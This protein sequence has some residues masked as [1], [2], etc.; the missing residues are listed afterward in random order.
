MNFFFTEFECL[1]PFFAYTLRSLAIIFTRAVTHWTTAAWR[2]LIRLQKISTYLYLLEEAVGKKIHEKHRLEQTNKAEKEE[3]S[4]TIE[5]NAPAVWNNWKVV[6]AR[7][8]RHDFGFSFLPHEAH[9]IDHEREETSFFCCRWALEPRES[10]ARLNYSPPCSVLHGNFSFSHC[11]L[12]ANNW[13]WATFSFNYHRSQAH[14]QVH[15]D[16]FRMQKVSSSPLQFI[17][18]A[19]KLTMRIKEEKKNTFKAFDWKWKRND[20]KQKEFCASSSW[21]VAN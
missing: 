14:S 19:H 16:E 10:L 9:V 1:S 20:A 8:S 3:R 17:V 21:H 12:S 7:K 18:V 15:N 2:L 11:S 13:R 6:V 5:E 4:L